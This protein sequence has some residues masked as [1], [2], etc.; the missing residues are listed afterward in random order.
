MS[1]GIAE[2]ALQSEVIDPEKHARLVKEIESVAR[3]ANI[4]VQ[5]VWTSMT[6]YCTKD[7]IDYVRELPKK[8]NKGVL[9]LVYVGEN[10]HKPILD[11][12]SA[13][14]AACIRNKINAQIMMVSDVIRETQ[15]GTLPNPTVLLI[16]NFYLEDSG[17]IP[18]WRSG[19]LLDMLYSRK[20]EGLQTFIYVQDMQGLAKDYGDSFVDHLNQFEKIP[21]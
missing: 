9:G 18:K 20:Q 11:R 5:M 14:A 17:D 21:A 1:I 19:A 8:R 6:Q 7:E 4:P 3:R 13:A 15:Q 10:Q 12:M 2:Q 16:P